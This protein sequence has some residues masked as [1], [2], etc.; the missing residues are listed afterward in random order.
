[1]LEKLQAA[2]KQAMLAKEAD[3]LSVIRMLISEVKNEAFTTQKKR[4]AD[5][6]VTAYL[7]KLTK[8]KEEFANSAEFVAKVEAEIKI[9][10]EFLPKALTEED[11]RKL[12]TEANLAEV[13]MKTV[14]PLL[15]GKVFDGKLAQSIVANWGKS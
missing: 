13:S 14:M 11:I 7:K 15:K 2:M 3:R 12:I 10:S 8:A 6:V 5:E 4:T 1:M 9:V